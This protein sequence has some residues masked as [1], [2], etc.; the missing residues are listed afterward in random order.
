M[1]DGEAEDLQET[2]PLGS[3]SRFAGFCGLPASP[4]RFWPADDSF[5]WPAVLSFTLSSPTINRRLGHKCPW[6]ARERENCHRPGPAFGWKE[7]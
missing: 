3:E 5:S 1:L 4:R 7:S 6:W 2:V